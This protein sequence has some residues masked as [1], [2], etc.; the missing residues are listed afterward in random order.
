MTRDLDD[1]FPVY[2]C[3]CILNQARHRREFVNTGTGHRAER[4]IAAFPKHAI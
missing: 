1:L 3:P 2:G 4:D